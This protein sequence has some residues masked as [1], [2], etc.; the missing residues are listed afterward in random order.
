VSLKVRK[1]V[2][3]EKKYIY[4]GSTNLPRINK[5]P[6]VRLNTKKFIIWPVAILS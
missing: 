2:I 6:V 3:N 4:L 5:L 1:S